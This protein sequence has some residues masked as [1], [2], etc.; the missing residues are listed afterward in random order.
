MA[1]FG[2]SVVILILVGPWPL[3]FP[4]SR[5]VIGAI[6]G[7]QTMAYAGREVPTETAL[8]LALGFVTGAAA[9]AAMLATPI[10]T[11]PSPQDAATPGPASAE[12]HHVK[13]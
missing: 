2:A 13:G 5:A 12:A 6:L 3:R 7:A 8:Y 11:A 4:L 9:V 1:L 10:P